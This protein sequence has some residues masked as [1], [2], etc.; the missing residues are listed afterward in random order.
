MIRFAAASLCAFLWFAGSASAQAPQ[1]D[2]GDIWAIQPDLEIPALSEGDPRPGRRVSQTTAGWEGTAV[3]HLVHLPTD[4]S[5]RK[6]WPVIIEY[7]GNGGYRN[8]FGD[9][10]DGTVEGSRLGYGLSGG[11]GFIW[12]SMPFVEITREGRKQNA[13][14]WWGDVEETK[15]YCIATV[16]NVCERWGG[17]PSRVIL[18]GF[19]RGSIACNYIGLQD[20]EIAK[21]WAGF[22]CHSHYDGVI[23]KWRYAAADRK[24][25]LIRLKRLGA[26]PQFISHEGTLSATRTWLLGTGIEGDWTFVS[27]PY[28]NHTDAWVLR[29]ITERDEARAWL[30]R[31]ANPPDPPAFSPALAASAAG[32]GVMALAAFLVWQRRARQGSRT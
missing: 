2:L 17:D 7:A 27:L 6:P 9:V 1:P 32:L 28:R 4:W 15:R 5:A 10:S 25:A 30:Q 19:S 22:F 16:R 12:V 21:L 13:I 24:S 26:R 8:A 11:R 3:H 31:F 29:N 23:E 18:C 14:K 20:D